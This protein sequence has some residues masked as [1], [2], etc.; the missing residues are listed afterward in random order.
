METL[1][2]LTL[3]GSILTLLLMALRYLILKKMPSTVY[4]Y[5]WLLVLL[6]FLLPL[7]GLLPAITDFADQSSISVP[8][9]HTAPVDD[10]V[11]F[12]QPALQQTAPV[13][14]ASEHKPEEAATKSPEV[15]PV[16]AENIS[17]NWRSPVLWLTVWGVGAMACFGF[18]VFS[19]L[20]FM[21][22][23]NRNLV[24]PEP[25]VL[26][27]YHSLPGHKPALYCCEAFKTPLM[28]GII[29]PKIIL[30]AH[31]LEEELLTNILR[32]E[33]M[34]YR[35]RDTLYKW[36]A[37]FVLSLH[38]FNPVAWLARKEI[39]RAC[40]LSCD[41]M[42]LRSM[43]RAEK[44]S[45][46]NTLLKIAASS[47][48]PAGVVATTFSTEKKNLKERLEQIMN[49]KKSGAR[50][51]AAV[52]ALVL[53][54]GVGIVVGPHTL[55]AESEAALP[56]EAVHVKNVDEFLAAI[57]PNTT[58]Y[59]EAG[60]Y[61]LSAASNY[62]AQT[63][64]PYYSWQQV[65]S[66]DSK[67]NAELVISRLDGLTIQG[68][69][70]DE[71]TI[72]AVPRYANVIRFVGCTN[73]NLSDLTAG[74]TTEPGFCSGGVLRLENCQ[75][76][77]IAACGLYGCGTI[78]VDALD[79]NDLIITASRIYECS[80]N[81]VA[82][83]QCRNV[84]VE[85]CDIN[86]HGIR[87]GE[88]EAMM[89]FAADYSDNFIVH[90]CSIHDNATQY[91][92]RSYYSKNTLFLSNDVHDNRIGA[93]MFLFEQYAAVV[94]GCRFE[95]NDFRIWVHD[96]RF[97]PIDINGEPLE[98]A[99]LNEMALRDIDPD[100]TVAPVDVEKA[101]EMRPGGEIA[102]KSVDEFLR[103]IGPDRT[104]ILDGTLFDLST[105]SNYGSSGGEYYSWTESHD[106]PQLVIRD[107]RGLTIRAAADDAK[108]TTLAAIPRYANV[109]SFRNCEDIQIIGFTAGHT[110]EPGACSGGVLEFQ[111][112]GGI[113][114]EGMRLY[115]CGILGIQA[116]RCT[117]L[118]I[119]RTEIY[120]CSQGAAQFFQCDGLNFID[121]DIHDVPSPALN[122]T[123]CGDKIWNSMPLTG[124]DSM[125]DVDEN[126]I[127][128]YETL[129][130]ED[131]AEFHGGAEDLVNP[132]SDEQAVIDELNT[133]RV[134]F[135]AFI[136]QAI[137]NDNWETLADRIA[138]PIQFFTINYSFVIHDR[139]EFL[140]MVQDE[141]FTSPF[142][143]ETFGFHQRITEADPTVFG[144]CVYGNTCLGH[145]I[146]FTCAGNTVTEDNLYITAFSVVTPLW[147]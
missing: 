65:W 30:P 79:C 23:L 99:E 57:R 56:A 98:A 76:I 34:H 106:G 31:S 29:H 82:L 27:V 114:I 69:G 28:C 142:F 16:A 124:L 101:T 6:R 36:F 32:H 53:L 52:L 95:A 55:R 104:I 86:S 134:N 102:V 88:S 63:E 100:I 58:I 117:S 44:Q 7:P 139:E 94:D 128:P 141:Y 50:M 107:V 73:L 62:G 113:R 24:K 118:D 111:N 66:G 46:G 119:R 67:T 10:T 145:L 77:N 3:S 103:A 133:P 120:E 1:F 9:N 109:V 42:L 90:G 39:S 131:E 129:P 138:F 97:D 64:S 41:E 11:V 127:I 13:Y 43:S 70:M 18:T 122:F 68:A 144:S 125:Y 60:E 40:E 5:A 80:Y 123:E 35:R 108:A 110:K 37:V 71:T 78:G 147:P 121:C 115:G 91:L 143:E 116:S 54:A 8:A 137:I 22:T 81:A 25:F 112:C 59:L 126:G 89:L 93:S 96:H 49:Y 33:L 12:Q 136:Q 4:Y 85:D 140:K 83:S 48:L 84:R 26:D 72:A 14:E 19:Y 47:S 87:P 135:A 61:D 130:V 45:Y 75:N 20:R 92:L 105:A 132:F 17:F 15:E 146:A 2:A 21:K 74:H 38:W 51:L